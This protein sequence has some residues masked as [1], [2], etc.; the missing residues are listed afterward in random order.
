M[1]IYD[2]GEITITHISNIGKPVRTIQFNTDDDKN[3]V[4]GGDLFEDLK[5]TLDEKLSTTDKKSSITFEGD[6]S[7]SNLYIS[8]EESIID[9]RFIISDAFDIPVFRIA[10]FTPL[11]NLYKIILSNGIVIQINESELRIKEKENGIKYHMGLPIDMTLYNSAKHRIES[12]EYTKSISLLSESN[13]FHIYDLKDFI[14]NDELRERIAGSK[15]SRDYIFKGFVQKYW[16]LCSEEMFQKLMIGTNF[17]D[18]SRI[19]INNY[20]Q[21]YRS[22]AQ[23]A[24]KSTLLK[25]IHRIAQTN[26]Y[27]KINN[28]LYISIKNAIIQMNDWEVNID[29]LTMFR[30]LHVSDMIP[31]ISYVDSKK[32]ITQR[33]TFVPK[34]A[35]PVL[36]ANPPSIPTIFTKSGLSIGIWIDLSKKLNVSHAKQFIFINIDRYVRVLTVWREDYKINFIKHLELIQEYINPVLATINHNRYK[37]SLDDF[38]MFTNTNT[39]FVNISVSIFWPIITSTKEFARLKDNISQ[40]YSAK[41]LVPAKFT[42]SSADSIGFYLTTGPVYPSPYAIDLRIH[43]DSFNYYSWMFNPDIFELWNTIYTGASIHIEHRTTEIKIEMQQIQNDGLYVAKMYMLGIL[44][45]VNLQETL[46]DQK[47]DKQKIVKLR[48][49]DPILYGYRDIKSGIKTKMYSIACQEPKQPLIMN[50]HEYDL[51]SNAKKKKLIK[52]W[53]FTKNEPVYYECPNPEYPYFGFQTGVHP[54]GFCLPC[55]QKTNPIFKSNHES[56]NKCLSNTNATELNE[57]QASKTSIRHIFEY[58]QYPIDIF[59]LGK[60]PWLQDLFSD[61]YASSIYLFGVTQ[62]TP[63]V[64][65]CGIVFSLAVIFNLTIIGFMRKIIKSVSDV[66]LRKDIY[67]L[68]IQ[69]KLEY[70]NTRSSNEWVDTMIELTTTT[71]GV[72]VI[73]I[74]SEKKDVYTLRKIFAN[75][76]IIIRK[77]GDIIEPIRVIDL[78]KFRKEI[79]LADTEIKKISAGNVKNIFTLIEIENIIKIPT[80]QKNLLTLL[81][82]GTKS[83]IPNLA[84]VKVNNTKKIGYVWYVGGEGLYLPSEL[85][86]DVT[87]NI[88][89]VQNIENIPMADKIPFDR[90]SWSKLNTFLTNSNTK[91]IGYIIGGD[92]NKAVAVIDVNN[93]IYFT[94]VTIKLLHETYKYNL[95]IIRWGYDPNEIYDSLYFV[96]DSAAEDVNA[97][98]EYDDIISKEIYQK[99]YIK[100][101]MYRHILLI[102]I[103]SLRDEK[104]I[105]VRNGILNLLKSG[106]DTEGLKLTENDEI[107]LNAL[108]YRKHYKDIQ[109][110]NWDSLKL[111]LEKTRFEF[112]DKIYYTLQDPTINMNTV[113]ENI[114]KLIDP[115]IK[116]DTS[117]IPSD[118]NF[119]IFYDLKYYKNN[120]LIINPIWIGSTQK[121]I[122][123]QLAKDLTNPMMESYFTTNIA[124]ELKSDPIWKAAVRAMTLIPGERLEIIVENTI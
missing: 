41:I 49:T 2:L 52:Y 38:P 117:V 59:R 57:D 1:N 12:D 97:I 91:V 20:P 85:Y 4:I 50:E 40:Y 98:Q 76:A 80:K 77:P 11:D 93:Y 56:Y 105:D 6:I 112:D 113:I 43:T 42:F 10:L 22:H 34:M 53:N 69:P 102:L 58:S 46:N 33:K 15:I 108:L 111:S 61:E 24:S 87:N 21:M 95:E 68:F 110:Q 71:F 122:I 54:T 64:P 47:T 124:I 72:G 17:D 18:E 8:G 27:K 30:E 23:L 101:V 115:Y 7:K 44:A 16:P 19:L 90:L 100:Y 36:M 51:L 31:I 78:K 107:Q 84:I 118:H 48:N 63:T 116:F 60:I 37:F 119:E 114:E 75:N 96:D 79:P 73:I 70:V 67:N 106:K 123:T 65:R 29:L 82:S 94:N 5:E 9:L 62:N 120:K 104:D 109:E 13:K 3:K 121:N 99:E 14:G 35:D 25:N 81:P 83:T 39:T 86:V 92:I 74:D 66:K 89:L 88:E 28:E 103:L 32:K 45:Q 55:C 26:T